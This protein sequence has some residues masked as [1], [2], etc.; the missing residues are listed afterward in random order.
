[1]IVHHQV[2][3]GKN[4][5]FLRK[6]LE[7]ESELSIMCFKDDQQSYWLIV[8]SKCGTSHN[9]FADTSLAPRLRVTLLI[10]AVVAMGGSWM[11]EQPRS[12]LLTWHPR[13]R[14]LWRLL[15]EVG[16]LHP[17]KHSIIQMILDKQASFV[18]I[19]VVSTSLM[20]PGIDITTSNGYS[21]RDFMEWVTPITFCL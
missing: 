12:S 6:G 16:A 14:L 5:F 19:W 10:L 1:M 3:L 21:W 15:P 13:I 20:I 2:G 4:V 11:V 9:P 18:F 8:L 17:K 7:L